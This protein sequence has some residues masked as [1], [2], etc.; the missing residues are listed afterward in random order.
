MAVLLAA[1]FAAP[2]AAAAE[3]RQ[4]S[5]VQLPA[6][7]GSRVRCGAR[8]RP[9]SRAEPREGWHP[10]GPAERPAG[11][12]DLSQGQDAEG[13]GVARRLRIAPW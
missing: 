3:S 1:G 4:G 5:P 10:A 2:A 6:A 11:R 8:S 9:S 13:R 12:G 7:R